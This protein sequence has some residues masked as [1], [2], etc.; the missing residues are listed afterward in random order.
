MII[1]KIIMD[2]PKA[3]ANQNGTQVGIE[4]YAVDVAPLSISIASNSIFEQIAATG[5]GFEDGFNAVPIHGCQQ[6]SGDF[7][8]SRIEFMDR[9]REARGG[10]L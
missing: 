6:L 4:F 10:G 1:Q 8:R 5:A 9:I 2:H 3:L 7:R